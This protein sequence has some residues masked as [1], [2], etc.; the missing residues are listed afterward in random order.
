[1]EEGKI[2]IN[3]LT[4]D[5]HFSIYLSIMSV[6]YFCNIVNNYSQIYN[7][8]F[9]LEKEEFTNLQTKILVVI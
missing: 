7:M 4:I 8:D 6:K 2:L 1:M 5:S 3:P 9:E